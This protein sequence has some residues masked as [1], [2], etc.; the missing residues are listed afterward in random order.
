M[1]NKQKLVCGFMVLMSIGLIFDTVTKIDKYGWNYNIT[2]IIDSVENTQIINNSNAVMFSLI[3]F[4]FT[5]LSFW[6]LGKSRN[7]EK[8]HKD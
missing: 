6:V 2:T 3:Y 4:I 1:L 8:F 5:A 7:L